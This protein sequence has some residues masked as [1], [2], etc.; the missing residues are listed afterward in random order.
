MVL[1]EVF[2]GALLQ[3][4][5]DRISSREVL[6]FVRRYVG[7]QK[8]LDKWKDTLKRIQGVLDDADEKQYDDQLVKLWLDNLI[9]L[10]YDV[11]DILDEFTTGTL[12]AE[13][14]ASTSKVRK[15][16]PACC[17]PLTPRAFKTNINLGPKISKI[18]ARFND[19]V[20]E[21]DELSLR[22][23]VDRRIR[24]TP[25]ASLVDE[26]Y[27]YGREGDKDA[28]LKLLLRN[29]YNDPDLVSVIP[30]HGMGGV[31][32]TTLAQLVFNDADVQMYFDVKVWTYVSDDFNVLRLTQ[33]IFAAVIRQTSEVK[34]IEFLKFNKDGEELNF[35]QC[36]LQKQLFGRKFLVILDNVWTDDYDKWNSL[37]APFLKGTPESRII[38]TTRDRGVASKMGTNGIG[39]HSLQV[40]SDEACISIFTLHAL[41]K[42]S[43]STAAPDLE[44]IGKK[45][46]EKCKGLPLAAFVFGGLLRSNEERDRCEWEKVS[47]RRILD[48]KEERDKILSV[49]MWS[50]H[51]LPLHLKKCFAHCSIIPEGYEF[52]EK[53]LVLLWMA[54]GLI[55]PQRE[56]QMEDLG[57]EYF[58]EL[59]RKSFFQ[60]SSKDESRFMMHDFINYLAQWAARG[61]RF[62]MDDRFEGVLKKARHLSYLCGHGSCHHNFEALSELTRLRTFL[63][64]VLPNQGQYPL[65]CNVS[66]QLLPRLGPLRVLSLSGYRITELPESIGDLIHLRY[67]DISNTSIES[68][69]ESMMTLYNLQTLI[70][71]NCPSLKKLPSMFRN[72]VN[73]RH[74]NIR[75]TCSLEGMPPQ[76]GKL[77][78]LQTLSDL[79]VGNG[80]CSGVKELGPLSHLRELCISRLENVIQLGDAIGANLIQKANLGWL[81]LEWSPNLNGPQNNTNDLEVLNALQPHGALKELIIRCYGG[82]EFPTWL[83]T[84]SFPNMVCLRLENCKKCK[85]LPSVGQLS[86]LKYLSI[87]GMAGVQQVG[88]EFYEGGQPFFRSLETLCFENMEEW[89]K[90]NPCE[91][92]PKLCE[93]SIQNC[94]K[95]SGRLPNYLPLKVDINGCPLLQ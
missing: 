77:T 67:L 6:N 22:E 80:T 47:K 76:M 50:Y 62:M 55:Q 49:L 29:E 69:P 26:D 81:L 31:G 13:N 25:S 17:T 15:L 74:L 19:I 58:Q 9:D 91:D 64:L 42:K 16:T 85:S 35:L 18:T 2:L 21:K 51:D 88:L 48:A 20:K 34:E 46:G 70:L 78:C 8:K 39:T 32:K 63:P 43:F 24:G 54:E 37:R 28:I 83:R 41:G 87:I 59:V 11:E 45:I 4:L 92:F 27:V 53:Q 14:Q 57:R 3:V 40:L 68:M 30:I 86:S 93:L 79:V 60:K 10:A 82:T 33:Q 71:E 7:L 84:P 36:E 23:N 5:F 61:T 95:L 38:I 1:A 56:K 94:P 89:R 65:T 12:I 52:E 90:W 72:L 66:L 73:L 44:G 75:K